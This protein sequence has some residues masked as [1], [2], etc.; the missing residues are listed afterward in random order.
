MKSKILI[1]LFFLSSFAFSQDD[2]RIISSDQNSILIEYTPVFLDTSSK[3]LDNQIF[4]N[5][6]LSFGYIPE[7]ELWGLPAIPERRFNIGVPAEFGNTI[8]VLNTKHIELQGN[9]VPKPQFVEDG[10]LFR[11]QYEVGRNYFD[12]LDNPELVLFGE[13]GITR[14]INNQAVKILPVKF[15]PVSNK[16]KLYQKIV[17]RITYSRGGTFS[18]QPYDELLS[19]AFINYDVAKYWQQ[20]VKALNK[21]TVVNSLLAEGDWLRFEAPEEG[22]YKIDYNFLSSAGFNPNEI[23]PRTLKLYNNGGKELSENVADPRPDDLV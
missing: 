12:Y 19:S 18:Q 14:G 3:V 1:L 21:V 2:F 22:I 23:D 11:Y 6:V 7:P 9:I 4:K 5:V 16:I 8:E 10:D 13:F 17:F 20:K 15:D